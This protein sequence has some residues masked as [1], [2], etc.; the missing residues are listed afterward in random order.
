[1]R[2]SLTVAACAII[3]LAWP[4]L[5]RAVG[6]GAA[7]TP[8]DWG[9]EVEGVRTRV[10]LKKSAFG[11]NEPILAVLEIK[12]TDEWRM[13]PRAPSLRS[14]GLDYRAGDSKAGGGAMYRG[15]REKLVR[16]RGNGNTYR[17]TL[18][19]G[20][21]FGLV[22]RINMEYE[23][24]L[25]YCVGYRG[26]KP[27]WA[28]SCPTTI[29]VEVLQEEVVGY[30]ISELFAERPRELRRRTR[31]CSRYPGD[32]LVELGKPAVLALASLCRSGK[33]VGLRRQA[34][35]ALTCFG[36]K[37][38]DAV[39]ALIEA[40]TKD[41]PG[42]GMEVAAALGAIGPDAEPA[43]PALIEALRPSIVSGRAAPALAKIGSAAIPHLIKA[44]RDEDKRLYALISLADFGPK[45][46]EAV[47]AL[48]PLLRDEG[49]RTRVW[50]GKALYS[51]GG[52]TDRVIPVLIDALKSREET[53]RLHA[54]ALLG[55]I[56]APAR[57]A[58]PH[59]TE[60]VGKE[61][62]DYVRRCMS[63]SLDRLRSAELP[64]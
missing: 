3:L 6:E 37:A 32:E 46:K 43:I 56:G 11:P 26:T 54:A 58:I 16:A 7:A 27:I 52:E 23:V 51:V 29:N 24:S 28:D 9:E 10:I 45:A 60:A 31:C 41:D 34:A 55:E 50:A 62:V 57:I 61:K 21:A 8:G 18:D 13:W 33:T 40:L 15:K 38:R 39:P 63:Q 49:E 64:D 17:A 14:V 59:L 2:A 47:P 22:P 35:R 4:G 48:I 44:L 53:A 20:E 25:G 30:Y 1:M 5:P 42:V 36:P 12:V 19:L